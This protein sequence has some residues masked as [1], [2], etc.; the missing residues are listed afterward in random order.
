MHA[1]AHMK[2]KDDPPADRRVWG[3]LKRAYMEAAASVQDYA[4]VMHGAARRTPTFNVMQEAKL[5]AWSELFEQPLFV[6][7]QKSAVVALEKS[8]AAEV[9]AQRKRVGVSKDTSTTGVSL[10]GLGEATLQ[11]ELAVEWVQQ[12]GM[13][14]VKRISQKAKSAVEVTLLDGMREGWSI[15]RMTREIRTVIG[16]SDR[17]AAAL[18][19]RRRSLEDYGVGTFKR[20]KDLDRYRDRLLK[21]RA[22]TIARTEVV[23]ARNQGQLH[24][25]QVMQ[26]DNELP[27]GVE[28]IWIPARNERTCPICITLGNLA[29]VPVGKAFLSPDVGRIMAPPAHPNCRCSMGLV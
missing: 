24:A 27:R 1:H 10:T 16:L 5:V 21:R 6:G 20:Q 8:R 2:S 4:R 7:W 12:R 14:L 23:A 17:D 19:R 26:E 13:E 15:Q 22:E 9:R 28:R 11:E 25:W 29:P 18:A 3:P